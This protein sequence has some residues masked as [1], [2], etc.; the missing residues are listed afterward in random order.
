MVGAKAVTSSSTSL[1]LA[2][3]RSGVSSVTVS[4]P[5]YQ[6]RGYWSKRYLKK[7]KGMVAEAGEENPWEL[8]KMIGL[9]FTCEAL[10]L[11]C[12]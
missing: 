4:L 1:R 2:Q 7:W 5:F 3:Q 6:V 10:L 11:L 12:L 8:I 9:P